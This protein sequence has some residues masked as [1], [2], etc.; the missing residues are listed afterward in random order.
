MVT[1]NRIFVFLMAGIAL[2]ACATG[3]CGTVLDLPDNPPGGTTR[4]YSETS[5]LRS[6]CNTWEYTQFFCQIENMNVFGIDLYDKN[7]SAET[8]LGLLSNTFPVAY[9]RP[10]TVFLDE[11]EKNPKCTK[12]CDI[13]IAAGK[14]LVLVVR[15]NGNNSKPTV[16]PSDINKYKKTLDKLLKQY[17]KHIAVLVVENE[18]DNPQYWAGTPGQYLQLLRIAADVAHAKGIKVANGGFSSRSMLLFAAYGAFYKV[19]PVWGGYQHEQSARRLLSISIG[20]GAWTNDDAEAWI[21]SNSRQLSKTMG[22]IGGVGSAGADYIN[23]H[24]HENSILGIQDLYFSLKHYQEWVS[25]VLLTPITDQLS[26]TNDNL[27]QLSDALYVASGI[28]GLPIVVWYSGDT[29]ISRPLVETDGSL[30][31]NGVFFLSFMDK[32]LAGKTMRA[33]PAA[34]RRGEFHVNEIKETYAPYT[35]LDYL[36]Q[37]EKRKAAILSNRPET[38]IAGCLPGTEN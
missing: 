4:V 22:L 28:T 37:R 34:T 29:G 38:P 26:T 17:K 11:F 16:P 35:D 20:P 2:L 7:M 32:Y 6:N 3:N 31:K 24:W 15:A 21:T 36:K 18:P 12:D 14:K 33:G 30:N 23:F 13:G 8:R 9:Y 27:L 5:R 1:I 19:T 25:P 10:E